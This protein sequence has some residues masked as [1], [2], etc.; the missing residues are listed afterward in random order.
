M[1]LHLFFTELFSKHRQKNSKGTCA[2]TEFNVKW[3]FKV[4]Q[5]DVF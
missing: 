5:G 3:P 2:K 4:I 1:G